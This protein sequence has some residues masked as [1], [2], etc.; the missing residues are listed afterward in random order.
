M[1]RSVFKKLE[2]KT[3]TK[4]I[5]NFV[6]VFILFSTALTFKTI[7]HEL[8]F[9]IMFFVGH[10]LA[11]IFSTNKNISLLGTP[12]RY[13]GFLSYLYYV[14]FLLNTI[15]VFKNNKINIF[16]WLNVL[17]FLVCALAISPYLLPYIYPFI[18]FNPA[19]FYNRVY[20][21]FGNP[22]YL[23]SFII[24]ILPIAI[25]TWK[26]SFSNK[27]IRNA[28][29]VMI[30]LFVV[31]LFL[32]GSRSA[33][34]A[35]I[36]SFGIFGILKIIKEKDYKILITIC[37]IF[38]LI[39]IGIEF[40]KYIAPIVP[41][42]ERLKLDTTKSNS[43][44]T[45]KTLWQ[46]GIKMIRNEP[47]TGYGHDMLQKNINPLLPDNLKSDPTYFIDRTHNELLDIILMHG[48]LTFIGYIGLISLTWINGIK[49]YVYE[50]QK[51]MMPVLIGI[52]SL[53]FYHIMN[54]SSI[55]SNILLFL[56][57][58][59]IISVKISSAKKI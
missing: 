33:W 28:N 10:I 51:S 3:G 47:F 36:L 58:G 29:I 11:F 55:T 6:L 53:N 9:L 8:F 20:G 23:A 46:I 31:T 57:I 21:T 4:F 13:Q 15:Y 25:F 54:F 56:M 44:A 14:L 37:I 30:F 32:T 5:A 22:N 1:D 59:Y 18:Y 48:F 19:F 41:Q 7:R 12:F 45:R 17:L 27:L 50:K 34:V 40:K 42:I 38:S 35:S 2:N 26:Q 39:L 49:I 16:K 52:T 43:I 24:A